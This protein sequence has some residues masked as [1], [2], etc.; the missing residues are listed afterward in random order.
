MPITA[1]G[2]SLASV[3]QC[4][5]A[6]PVSAKASSDQ[7]RAGAWHVDCAAVNR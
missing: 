7:R 5:R 1:V 4:I 3:R 2:E 6:R